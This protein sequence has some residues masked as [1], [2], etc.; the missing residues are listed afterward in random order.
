MSARTLHGV[1]LSVA[2]AHPAKTAFY[3]L[4]PA[5]E[6]WDSITYG[7][8]A[9]MAGSAAERL[10]G[11]GIAPGARVVVIGESS[12]SWCAA[13]LG[14]LMAGAIAVPIDPRLTPDEV[15]NLVDD[16][17]A[18]AVLAGR[19]AAATVARALEGRDIP[20]ADFASFAQ[21][22]RGKVPEATPRATGSED[23]DLA[24]LL[25]T[26]G[27]TGAPKA[28]MLT[29]ENFLG[30]AE[31]LAATGL[32]TGDDGVLAVLPLHHTYAFTITLLYPLL[33][34]ASITYPRALKGPDI[35]N[36]ARATGGTVL[37]GVPQVLEMMRNRIRDRLAGLPAPARIFM[38]AL[39]AL[40]RLVRGATGLNLIRLAIRNPM[41][42]QFRFIASGGA[43]LAPD[44]MRD[45]ESYGFTV[46]EGYGL[47]ETS[48]VL[49]F[50]PL[51]RRKPGSVGVAISSAEIRIDSPDA[52]TGEGEVLAR[53]P[54]VMKGYA[55]LPEE[56][57]QALA[58]GWFHTG[59]MGRIDDEG[60]LFITGR[61]KEIIVLGSGKNVYPEEV[62][63]RF[64]GLPLVAELC[65]VERRGALHLVI[66][67][68][69]DRARSERIANI[70]ETLKWEINAL[71]GGLP[72]QMRPTGF[73]L[74]QAPLPRTPL[75]KLR[76][77]MIARLAEG[78]Q[79]A[80]APEPA[81][82]EKW[83]ETGALVRETLARHIAD[84]TPVLPGSSLELDL[85][86]DSLKR[87]EVH[88]SLEEALGRRL[89]D[90]ALADVQTVR[91]LVEAIEEGRAWA[92]ETSG[93][94]G[95]SGIEAMLLREPSPEELRQ[96]GLES[97][98]AAFVLATVALLRAYFRLRH[99]LRTLGA[100][101]IPDSPFIVVANHASYYDAFC[102]AAALPRRVL[103]HVYTQG[104]S[105]FFDGPLSSRLARAGHV[106]PIDPD[107][108][109]GGALRLSAHVLRTGRSLMIF[110]EGGRSS[111]GGLMPFMKGI[112]ILARA[113]GVP[114]V[115]ARI[116]GAYEAW[117]RDRRFPKGGPISVS[118]GAPVGPGDWP[119]A[120]TGDPAQALAD[121]VRARIAEL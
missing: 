44:V 15:R 17:G 78:E 7:R 37:V 46:L 30:D 74:L 55:R 65:V 117:P 26:S 27:T 20:V 109:L 107:A 43:R 10:Y 5:T 118:F 115:P 113:F 81:A 57:A 82:P 73:T 36:A 11:L 101:R 18:R 28:V 19:T 95:A 90:Q 100:E 60:Y 40:A 92:E 77:F 2:R 91:E 6:T 1:L 99:G 112:G 96:A 51:G 53:G 79:R 102:L 119:V 97:G 58:G 108:S 104:A 14:T 59:D 47:T 87:I 84:D 88:V 85:G 31:A 110:P 80:E 56:T 8:F 62:E 48:P 52:A 71:A 23:D 42:P 94:G 49:T 21:P 64:T 76:R 106:I 32:L 33:V 86:L 75:G 34:G 66:V 12:P 38:R 105:K 93:A 89:S 50:T 70:R 24:S 13:Y 41:G 72:P 61:K 98:H 114:I 83:S 35:V 121:L 22:L 39:I 68:D 4:D 63:A 69:F 9:E 103:P 3:V 67:P 120:D 25:Y 16:S 116:R 29:H 111:D 45:L 54:M